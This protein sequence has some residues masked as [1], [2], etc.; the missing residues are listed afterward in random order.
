MVSLTSST[1]S[2]GRPIIKSML[3]SGIPARRRL[4]NISDTDS[5]VWFLPMRFK[6]RCCMVWGLQLTRVTPHCCMAASF[7]SDILSGRPASTVNSTVCSQQK[8]SF[9]SC[10]ISEK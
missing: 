8:L 3:I 1:P 4:W 2:P 6:V 5:T 7:T 9:T 10:S